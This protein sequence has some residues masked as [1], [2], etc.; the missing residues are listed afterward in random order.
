MRL[1]PIIL[2]GGSGTRLWPESRES[3]PK[4]F[5]NLFENEKSL[6]DLT[7]ERIMFSS[8]YSRPVVVASKNHLFIVKNK[9][10]KYGIDAKILLEPEP[11]NT[12]AAIYL[13]AKCCKPE[14]NLIIMPSDHL[15]ED[16][17]KFD[18]MISELLQM[19]NFENWITLGI[20]PTKALDS[21]GYIKT[22]DRL[23]KK[24]MDVVSFHEKPNIEEAKKML[25]TK[26]YFWNSGIFLSKCNIVI[27]S[28][29]NHAPRIGKTCNNVFKNKEHSLNQNE[30]RFK[31]NL[32][33][34]IPSISIDH[35]VLEKSHNIKL[36]PFIGKWSDLGSWDTISQSKQVLKHKD[37]IQIRSK[38]NFIRTK[39]RL[40][41]TIG[42]ED[43]III[44]SDDATLI[45][46]KNYTQQVKDVVTVLRK[47]NKNKAIEH[48]FET[49]P[50]GNFEILSENS[51]CKVKKLNIFPHKRLSLQYHN[52]RSEH[53][54][55]IQ[56]TAYVYLDG[57]FKKMLPG[58]S[59]D[60]PTKSKHYIENRTDENLMIIETQLGS[61]FGEDDIVRIDDPYERS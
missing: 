8:F 30:I 7:L 53:W 28:V 44:D 4:Q 33:K 46:K 58:Q 34:K 36:Y 18:K 51:F 32:F 22:C 54:V 3:L 40:I 27:N 42:I 50:W 19:N 59:I 31:E 43:L 41:A 9:L 57:T 37:I 26:D 49:R 52:Y 15:I 6:F 16:N 1:R 61:Y 12:T 17:T 29:E 11:K 55:I 48:V 60:V 23:N 45:S 20:K 25:S 38:N 39:N 2:C 10:K 47:K 56:G 5:I 35:S 13:A 14:D 24:L 21:Y